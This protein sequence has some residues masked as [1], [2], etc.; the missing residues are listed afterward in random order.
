MPRYF[1]VTK[2]KLQTPTDWDE[3]KVK[4]Y[5]YLSMLSAQEEKSSVEMHEISE[6]EFRGED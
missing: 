1:E 4:Q 6:E 2:M 3:N 5:L